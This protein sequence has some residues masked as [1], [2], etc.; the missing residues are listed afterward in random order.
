MIN[1]LKRIQETLQEDDYNLYMN[2]IN[3]SPTG[4]T[5][6]EEKKKELVEGAMA[7]AIDFKNRLYEDYGETTPIV[8]LIKMGVHLNYVKEEQSYNY[9]YLGY[10]REKTKSIYLNLTTIENITNSAEEYG[11]ENIEVDKLKDTVIMHELFHYLEG[12]YVDGFSNEKHVDVKIFGIFKSK[13]SLSVVSEIA[14]VHF[15]KLVTNLSHT[16]LVYNQIY[17]LK[18]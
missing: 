12:I 5:L 18:K 11:L 16:P 8:Y 7:Q 9:Q 10:Y 1:T 4:R 13:S 2:M 17:K 15:S 6:S 3:N 14:S